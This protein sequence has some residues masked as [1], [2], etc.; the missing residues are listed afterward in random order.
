MSGN[1]RCTVV[2]E[3]QQRIK[4][5]VQTAHHQENNIPRLKPKVTWIIEV[6]GQE[7]M[8]SNLELYKIQSSKLQIRILKTTSVQA[9]MDCLAAE[10]RKYLLQVTVN[11]SQGII[12]IM[13]LQKKKR[14]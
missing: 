4:A 1:I 13:L 14:H 6:K 8:K 11:V 3:S 12:K 5:F 9:W 10:Q 2:E 7:E